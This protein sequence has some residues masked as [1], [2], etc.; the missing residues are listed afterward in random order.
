MPPPPPPPPGAITALQ[1]VAALAAVWVSVAV[2]QVLRGLLGMALGTPLRGFA[3]DQA[4][5]WLPV[6]VQGPG[7]S[8]TLGD[9]TLVA[10]AGTVVIP[11]LA[12]GLTLLL[13]SGRTWGWLQ[14]FALVWLVVGALWLPTALAA[15]SLTGSSGPVA[16]LYA[17]LGDPTAGRWTALALGTVVLGLVPGPVSGLAVSVG[18]RWMRADAPE[19]RRRLVR[20]VAGWPGLVAAAALLGAAG[21]ARSP[22]L[23]PWP[24]AV[25]AAFHI[26]TR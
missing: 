12:L 1:S 2:D 24:L 20:V 8:Q 4:H 15:A 9:V 17:R 14:G 26:R 22:W 25:L 18:R 23:A 3:L 11:L 5:A 10:L 13:S 6:A 21:W 7:A 19:F 16:E